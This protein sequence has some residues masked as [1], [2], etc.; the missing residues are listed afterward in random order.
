MKNLCLVA[1]CLLTVMSS[2]GRATEVVTPSELNAHPDRYDGKTVTVRGYFLWDTELFAIVDSKAAAENRNGPPSECIG[3]DSALDL[4]EKL[5]AL[6][7]HMVDATGTFYP[8]LMFRD[9]KR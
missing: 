1:A 8:S 4:K 5:K 9:G 2:V 7:Q 3:Y 6:N